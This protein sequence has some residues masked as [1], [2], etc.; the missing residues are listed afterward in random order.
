MVIMITR[1]LI[2]LLLS[3]ASAMTYSHD[4]R[5]EHTDE[6]GENFYPK[7]EGSF[8]I[9]SYNVGAFSK[10]MTDSTKDIARMIKE[11]EADIVGLNELDSCNT[12]H[13]VNQVAQLAEELDWQWHFGRAMAYRGG[14]YGNG[15]V[16]PKDQI[17]EEMYT[18][19]LPQGSGSEQ[20]SIA[21]VETGAYV[22]GAVHL[23]Y[24]SEEAAMG[25]I[26][27]VNNWV[28]TRY[29][30]CRKPVFLI[31]DMNFTPSSNVIKALEEVWTR[32]S[33][34][35]PTIPVDEPQDC[36]DF[37]FHYRKSAPVKVTGTHTMTKFRTGDVTEASDHLPVYADVRF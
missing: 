34:T 32:L 15:I 27:V 25:Q 28:R 21:V 36:I 3:S 26:A 11:A 14:A 5:Q 33:S 2:A 18:V 22:L 35:E 20:R 4:E 23:D 37:I 24:I 19:T 8:R 13:N 17:I 1:I 10:F 9:M 16:V 29:D 7:A 30:K 12:R 31:G 6:N